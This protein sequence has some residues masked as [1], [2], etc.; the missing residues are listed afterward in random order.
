MRAKTELD[1]GTILIPDNPVSQFLFSNTKSAII[2]LVIRLYLGYAW[3]TAGWKK[4]TSSAW[5][6][7]DAGVAVTGFVNGALAKA[8]E[9]GEVTGWYAWFLEN[10]VLP[11]AKLFSFFVAYGEVLV[12]LGLILGLLTG[13]AAFFGGLMNVTF[14]FA[15][16]LSTNP[17]LFILAT[18]LVMAWKVAG[19]YG[20][21]RWALTY[22]GT[23][24]HRGHGGR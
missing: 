18:W 2:W 15:G 19:W 13:I 8:E 5:V 12:G 9:G 10:A 11:N 22:L 16:T 17:L 7:E 21:D 14:L 23:P 20:L 6:G 1:N 3:V 4:V 24:W